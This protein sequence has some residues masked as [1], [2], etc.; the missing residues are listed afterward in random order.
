M[1]RAQAIM[2]QGTASNVGKSMLCTALCRIF[3]QDGYKTAP[4]KAQNMALNSTVTP[5]GGEIGRARA[6]KPRLPG[7]SQRAHE[8]HPHQAQTGQPGPDHNPGVLYADMS[9]ADYRR[10]FLPVRCR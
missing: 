3:A 1:R 8:P 9:A 4:F 7:G 10:D 2:I 5:E 6:L